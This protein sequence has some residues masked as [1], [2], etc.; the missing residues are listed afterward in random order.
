MRPAIN[1]APTECHPDHVT[2]GG[3]FGNLLGE[4]L[5]PVGQ[6][7]LGLTILASPWL[8]AIAVLQNV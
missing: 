4:M 6:V 5:Y 8:I 2:K 1:I 3:H 7:F